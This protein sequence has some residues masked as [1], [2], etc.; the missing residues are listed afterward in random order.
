MIY[1]YLL[2]KESNGEFLRKWHE[3]STEEQVI[4][5]NKEGKKTEDIFM[6]DDEKSRQE[7]DIKDM[8][9][10]FCRPF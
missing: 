3:D 5:I 6:N 4:E 1:K 9:P 2:I 10:I 7:V 8:S